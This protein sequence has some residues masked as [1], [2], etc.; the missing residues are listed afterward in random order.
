[1]TDPRT[2]ALDY[3]SQNDA[4]FVD[5]LKALCAIPSISTDPETKSEVRRAAQ[6]V[7]DHLRGLGIDNVQFFETTGHPIVYGEWLKAGPNA[8]TVLV[9]GHYDVQPAEP[10]DKWSADPFGGEI[11]G[12]QIFARG[13]TDMKGQ[14][15]ASLNA[16]EAILKTH[17]ALPVNV[18]F[19]IEGEEEIGSPN[20]EIFIAEHK[21][22]LAC[23]MALNP[24]TGMLAVDTPTITYGLRGLAYFEVHVR[25]A[26]NDL[27]S[28]VF[29]GAVHNAAQVLCE[30]I[31]GMHDENGRVTLP[32]FYDSVREISAEERAELARLPFDEAAILAQSGAL[33]LWEGERGYT[34]IERV[35]ARPTLEVNG[36]LS[37]FTGEGSKTVLPA[38]AMAK[39]SCRLVPD[40]DHT[41]I[42]GMLRT[43]LQ[44]HAP[45][46]IS[47]EVRSMTG[48][49]ASI[50][51][52]N[53]PGV[54]ALAQGM[55]AVWG[56]RPLF[57]RE[58]GSVP[59]V[60][61]MQKLLGVDS[62][63]TGFALPGDNM[64]GPDETLHLPTWRKGTQALVHFFFNLA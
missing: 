20:L 19:M 41:Q 64:H 7:A 18:K 62:V 35:G 17:G 37:G 29:G 34:A 12:E 43:Y 32:G 30:L 3:L 49:A 44:Q 6:W 21:D 13:A 22:L 51:D 23:D 4:R 47:W 26:K 50:S 39:I 45:N 9:Y 60:G 56:K 2:L 10:L 25:G 61:Q 59:V 24:D 48:G 15:L 55:E 8:K 27:H 5:E 38:R 58:G 36:I 11:R 52:R 63:N 1:M 57:K 42:E 16:I 40:Q 33:A 14:V 28:G 31:A 53:S 54:Q 46:T